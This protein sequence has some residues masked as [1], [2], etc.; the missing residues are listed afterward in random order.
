MAVP[1]SEQMEHNEIQPMGEPWA[2]EELERIPHLHFLASSIREVI[3]ANKTIRDREFQNKVAYE[4]FIELCNNDLVFFLKITQQYYLLNKLFEEMSGPKEK[5]VH[6]VEDLRHQYQQQQL[7]QNSQ[8]VAKSP[9]VDRP[10]PSVLSVPPSAFAWNEPDPNWSNLRKWQHYENELKRITTNYHQQKVAVYQQAMDEDIKV[11]DNLLEQLDKGSP[12]HQEA[13]T[14]KNDLHQRRREVFSRNLHNAK[15]ELD[16]NK[17]EQLER[18]CVMHRKKMQDDILRCIHKFPKN[19]YFKEARDRLQDN[20]LLVKAKVNALDVDYERARSELSEK[21]K[22]CRTS[23]KK[24]VN[25][26]L[27]QI[28]DAIDS[29]DLS[30]L[31]EVE[32]DNLVQLKDKLNESRKQLASATSGER[33][34][35]VLRD[36]TQSLKE[37]APLMPASL[38]NKIIPATEHLESMVVSDAP[39]IKQQHQNHGVQD[40]LINHATNS[41]DPEVEA[42]E[43]AEDSDL[44]HAQVLDDQVA[45]QVPS[46]DS[47]LAQNSTIEKVRLFKAQNMEL[48]EHLDDKN[49]V[50]EA[51]NPGI[52]ILNSITEQ[53]ERIDTSELSAEQIGQLQEIKSLIEEIVNNP[54]QSLERIDDLYDLI[55]ESQEIIPNF[56]ETL[57]QVMEAQD[58]LENQV[59]HEH[60]ESAT[61]SL[62]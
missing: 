30:E 48:R 53:V 28:A 55:M 6:F 59:R 14:I 18:D 20:Q 60:E 1:Q 23:S 29:M 34:Q 61:L 8:F 40:Q 45:A 47:S 19:D 35:E 24:E 62:R 25:D 36:I 46:Q 50:M 4:N 49:Q 22:E 26:E 37:L 41:I 39:K 43:L 58:A 57:D 33:Y 42:P 51:V 52:D 32:K 31:S 3:H 17:V 7:N 11:M 10:A 38:A 21:I 15:G 2:L 13:L 9:T 56:K 5:W 27:K 16:A 54:N 44:D 12:E